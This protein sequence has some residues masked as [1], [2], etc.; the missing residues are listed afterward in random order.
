MLE[1]SIPNI[2]CLQVGREYESWLNL[3]DGRPLELWEE[4]Q[5]DLER[6]YYR[7]FG[8]HIEPLKKFKN[9]SEQLLTFMKTV[10][11]KLSTINYTGDKT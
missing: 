2:A 9:L 8:S 7:V 1:I 6:E 10:Y 4:E 3:Y 5:D 11:S